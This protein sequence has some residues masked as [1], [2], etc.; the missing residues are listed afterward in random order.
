MI[1]GNLCCYAGGLLR[2]P[3]YLPNRWIAVQWNQL[4]GGWRIRNTSYCFFFLVCLGFWSIPSPHTLTC[5][6]CPFLGRLGTLP[7]VFFALFVMALLTRTANGISRARQICTDIAIPRTY[8]SLWLGR[9]GAKS[10]IYQQK[11]FSVN[12]PLNHTSMH[13]PVIFLWSPMNLSSC[14][15][16]G[17]RFLTKALVD[18][19]QEVLRVQ[20]WLLCAT[21]RHCIAALPVLD[22]SWG[23]TKIRVRIW[24]FTGSLAETSAGFHDRPKLIVLA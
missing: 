1:H 15:A 7:R 24:T 11:R 10:W 14:H 5:S 16:L 19:C 22:K 20:P 23:P 8:R 3:I 17:S 12:F 18:L 21:S 9:R 13:I 6:N 2:E 4:F